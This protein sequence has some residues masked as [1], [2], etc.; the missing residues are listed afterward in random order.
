MVAVSFQL[1]KAQIWSNRHWIITEHIC[2]SHFRTGSQNWSTCVASWINYSHTH[3][4]DIH[5]NAGKY[6]QKITKLCTDVLL[7]FRDNDERPIVINSLN[8]KLRQIAPTYI[9]AMDPLTPESDI[10]PRLLGTVP[11]P[12]QNEDGS[13]LLGDV[14]PPPQN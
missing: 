5:L 9:W 3:Y 4:H 13:R 8:L 14:P 10:R 1:V 12:P 6:K 2:M 11:P 7:V